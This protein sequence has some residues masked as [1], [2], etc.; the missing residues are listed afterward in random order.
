MAPFRRFLWIFLFCAVNTVSCQVNV[1]GFIRGSVLLPCIYRGPDPLPGNPNV[2]WM[3]KDDNIVLT[4]MSGV[5]NTAS[6]NQNFRGRVNSFPD[7]YTSG[8][9][10]IVLQNVQ[11]SDSGTYECH[12][13]KVDFKQRVQ[14]T[15]TEKRVDV[16]ATPGPSAGNAAVTPD[17]LLLLLL[18]L[19][20]APLS[21]PVYLSVL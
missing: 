4:V 9:F 19:L 2:S 7:L 15:V 13:P 18:L 21:L 17:S 10:S 11:L 20:L 16:T 6:Q 12:I 1:Q 14:L 3:D 5:Q 8:N